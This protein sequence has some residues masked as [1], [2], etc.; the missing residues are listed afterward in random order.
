M[1]APTQLRAAEITMQCPKC[2]HQGNWS[3]FYIDGLGGDLPAGE[4]RCPQCRF[5]WTN[6]P[7]PE[8]WKV[9]HGARRV[10]AVSRPSL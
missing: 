2:M 3:G 9:G 10:V 6:E 7:D 8:P 1:N 5:Q 4:K